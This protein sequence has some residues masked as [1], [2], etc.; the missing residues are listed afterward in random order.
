ML[1]NFQSCYKFWLV[2]CDLDYNLSGVVSEIHVDHVNFQS[3]YI[4]FFVLFCLK[5]IC[6]VYD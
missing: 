3:Y 5:V 4:Y 1:L 6:V 2:N